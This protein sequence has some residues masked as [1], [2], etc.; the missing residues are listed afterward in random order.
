MPLNVTVGTP[1]VEERTP[2]LVVTLKGEEKK[3]LDLQL[4]LRSALNGDLMILDHKDIDIIIQPKN[5][6]VVTFAKDILSDVVYGAE[7]RLLEYL[8]SRG[9]IE[10]DSIQGGNVYGSLEG[11]IMNSETHD[12]IKATLINISEWMKTEQPYMKA[13]TAY[14]QME[15]DA[16][17]DPDNAES[18]D[19]GQ[20]D[21]AEKK[22][23]IDPS[24][25]FAPYMYGRFA[26]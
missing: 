6:K 8:R 3:T 10:Y 22:G 9:V 14:E 15:E 17:I 16:L 19:L 24:T 11:R 5:N 1:E 25:I 26:Y 4:R 2:D 21:Q 20:V 7:S 18:T 12:P 23:S 13:V